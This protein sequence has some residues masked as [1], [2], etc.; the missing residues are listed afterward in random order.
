MTLVSRSGWDIFQF[1]DFRRFFG[2]RFLTGLATQV[3]N[4]GLGWLV[5]DKTDSALALGL[6]GLAA[7]L[8]ALLLA[9]VAGAAADRFDRR[10]IV[11]VCYGLL[12]VA[13]AGLLLTALYPGAPVW[14]IYGLAVL[15][16]A[17]RSFANPASQALVPN[18]VPKSHFPAAV[19]FNASAWQS[20]SIMGPA[21]GGLLYVLGPS[22][23]FGVSSAC[24]AAAS[25][26]IS[27][28]AAPPQHDLAKRERPTLE[29]LFAGVRFIRSRP[30][31]LGAISLDL[32]AVLLGGAVALLPIYARDIL[33]TGPWGLG[34]LR[35]MPAAGAICTTLLLA[36]FP[37][38][39]KAGP[40]MFAAVATFGLA[41][42]VFGLSTSLVVSMAALFVTGAVD[43]VSVVVRQTLVQLETPDEMRGRVSAVN[44]VFIGASN[45]L[46]EFESGVLA[47]AIGPV[48]SAVL[49][50]VGTLV[51]VALWIRLFPPLWQRDALV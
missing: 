36:W 1:R 14:P 31:I 47:A 41:T 9:L 25:L 37:I 45:E 4:V 51:V 20:S 40:R 8:P 29:T 24:F 44:S 27:T 10:R 38:R 6:V 39:S 34:L 23:V 12:A 18:I 3:R 50:G 19:T 13:D 26:L 49:G 46:G 15:V 35:S 43:M 32:F 17:G 2:A 5:Y 28:V 30:V 48:G 7:F 22:V 11:T 33:H 16:G 42:I 21:V